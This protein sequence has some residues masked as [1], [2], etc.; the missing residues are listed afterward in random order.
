MHETPSKLPPLLHKSHNQGP[1]SF[2][3]ESLWFL[4]QLDPTNL[5]Y[6]L[7]YLFRLSGG[8]N[9]VILEQVLNELVRRHENLRTVFPNQAG[10]PLQ[11]VCPFE[12]F[13]LPEVDFSSLPQEE[14]ELAISKYALKQGK[15]QFNIHGDPLT[16]F[17]LLHASSQEDYLFFA[18]HHIGFDGWSQQILISELLQLYDDFRSSR[19]SGI[20]DL[21]FQYLDYALWQ[22]AWLSGDTLNTFTDH[23]KKILSGDFPILDLPADHPRPVMQTY[24]GAKYSF[25]LSPSISTLI[26]SFCKKEHITPFHLFL[27]TYAVLL[28]RYT[29]Q[30]DIITGCPFSNRPLPELDGI[31]GAF[32]N[33]LPIR[34]NLRGNPNVRCLLKQVREVMEDAL[35]WQAA[36]FETLVSE[37]SPQRDLDRTPVFQ[38]LINM[39]NLPR[40]PSAIE[41]LRVESVL[42]EEDTAAFDLSLE[43]N[44]EGNCFDLAMRYNVS[45]FEQTTILHLVSHFQNILSQMLNGP[46][47]FLSDLEMLASSERQRIVQDW[48]AASS[49]LPQPCLH[50]M[51]S[52][53]AVKN[54][55]VP[56][57]ICN[58]RQLTYS[59][60]EKS[61]NQLS[62][63]LLANGCGAGTLVGIYLPR[64]EELLISQLAILK[65]GGAYIPLDLTY[66]AERLLNILQDA[67]PA[68]VITQSTLAAQLPDQCHKICM[69]SEMEAINAF[70]CLNRPAPTSG[71]AILYVTYTSGSTGFPKGVVIGQQGVSNYLNYL[72]STFRLHSGE[73]VIQ[74]TPLSFDAACRDTLG[75]LT[76]GG[77]VVL[78]DDNQMRDPDFISRTILE[79]KINCIL[80]VVPTMLRA[81]SRSTI[82]HATKEHCLRLIMS[83]GEALQIVDVELVRNAFG[84]NVQMVNQYG[85]SECSMISTMYRVPESFPGT[86]QAVP[87][88]RPINNVRMYILDQN[89]HPVPAGAKGELYIGGMAVGHGYLNLPDLTAERFLPDPF[90]PKGQMY[91]TGDL[92][93]YAKDG[94]LFYLG[95]MDQ[96][97]KIRGYRVELEEIEAV[98]RECPGILD[99]AVVFWPDK[100]LE[101]LALYVTLT[102]RGAEI[103]RETLSLYLENRL[104]FYMLPS[105]TMVLDEMPLT[106]N[107]K[108]NRRALPRPKAGRTIDRYLAPRN[109][110]EMRLVS[111]WKEVLGIEQVGV[112]NNFFELGGHSLLAVR[113]LARVQE[114][115]CQSLPLLLLFKDGTVEVMARALTNNKEDSLQ[116]N[117]DV[118]N[119]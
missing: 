78:L 13:P 52:A 84:K 79:K 7:T 36:P 74:F 77:T 102:E 85:P 25:S 117:Q 87:I 72:V 9:R 15:V 1:L 80:S 56:A 69:D 112:R 73:R 119:D 59:A 58:G 118:E 4:Y 68:L 114:E 45:L 81:I 43:I 62:A 38:V 98:A 23:W 48:N 39:R 64:S 101:L 111:I 96:Q 33:T 28:M 54:P 61:A 22:R 21:P 37:I 41:G 47:S 91:R 57:I 30:E 94:T 2:S 110:V 53:Q 31:I 42:S 67:K 113:L 66:P 107:R 100:P 40:R 18:T 11:I 14:R 86:L 70:P 35:V 55:D 65:S 75:V 5:A 63:Y 93:R 29:G 32:I 10:Q 8:V 44:E 92:A 105:V 109:D 116:T 17:T 99:A 83:S 50:E 76:F 115:F 49:E 60:L 104:P 106:P 108:I 95:R 51:V 82:E 89:R 90:L 3:Q 26:K 19:A 6:N 103:A 97:V 88:G 27:A 71:D 20:P 46:E 16:R 12:P 24:R 34:L